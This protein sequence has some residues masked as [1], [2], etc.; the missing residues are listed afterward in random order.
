[1]KTKQKKLKFSNGEISERL[2]ER[3]DL[4]SLD[5]SASYIRNMIST[6]YGTIRKRDGLSHVAQLNLGDSP[7]I[8]SVT[9]SF[10]GGDTANLYI[11]DEI[12][13]SDVSG[14]GGLSP[15][16]DILK[17]EMPTLKVYQY[18]K[19]N[20]IIFREIIGAINA[21]TATAGVITNLSVV[22]FS[23]VPSGT[24]SFKSPTGGDP[25]IVTW[26]A[27]NTGFV[28]SATIDDG[29][30]GFS[31]TSTN[32]LYAK[33][34]VG[35]EQDGG[36]LKQTSDVKVYISEDDIT[37]TLLDTISVNTKI[38]YEVD[39]SIDY[40][41]TPATTLKYIKFEL[42]NSVQSTLIIN[43]LSIT[44][45]VGDLT[46]GYKLIPFEV[47]N[48]N[49]YLLV[50]SNEEIAIYKDDILLTFIPAPG[51][52]K[53]T[54]ENLKYTQYEDSIVFTHK[55]MVT[56]S[57]Q[58]TSFGWEY[59]D[60]PFINIPFFRFFPSRE[61]FPVDITP[62]ATEGRVKITADSS[63]FL[64][65]H[66]GQVIDGNG[67]RVRITE[68]ES[69]LV[70]FGYT[71]IPFYNT[72][73]IQAG[74]T[75]ADWGMETGYEEVWSLDKGYPITCAFYQQRLWFGGTKTKPSTLWASRINDYA[76]FKNYANYDNDSIELA[77]SSSKTN[78]I[79]NIYPNRG[80]QVF[81]TGDEF[82]VPEGTLTPTR[83][84]IVK[85]TSNGSYSSVPVVDING[86]SLF[87]EKNGKN[88]LGFVFDERQG[89]YITSQISLLSE[90]VNRPIAMTVDYN[91]VRGEGN[92]LYMVNQDGTIA[93]ACILLDQKINSFTR[94][95]TE[96]TFLDVVSLESDV[97]F[98][99]E[100]ASIVSLEKVNPV[101]SDFTTIKSPALTLTGLDIYNTLTI[102]VYNDT[103]E[104]E[105]LVVN[106]EVTLT[107]LPTEDVYVGLKFE[108]NITSNKLSV[109]MATES[110][111][112]R[113]SR[114][115][116]KT[117]DTEEIIFNGRKTIAKD[118]L[119]IFGSG[120][121]Y[122]RDNRFT[123][124]GDIKNL[125][126]ASIV[127]DMNYGG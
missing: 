75:G 81:T 53:E 101:Q 118:G 89:S 86:V 74:I 15:N 126:I 117:L 70:V 11:N 73:K 45:S 56:K 64:E 124:K 25:L 38:S 93:V 59:K 39:L 84:S 88:L 47:S 35:W 99:V 41:L 127:L 85:N 97:Y 58:R 3:S 28:N 111:K 48:E 96:G 76:D 106:G 26:V 108:Y 100:R 65:E 54:F 10:I 32:F 125:E 50:L 115:V 116:I 37:Y 95:E 120:N 104:E 51:L 91:S 78:E 110:I 36:P 98:I 119:F 33:D 21:G 6:P 103:F 83:I 79:V 114:A 61:S 107:E 82:L 17:M 67:G 42:V 60:F 102:T 68:Y 16:T 31:N 27:N 23:G 55:D 52:V 34:V 13:T 19:I 9:T 24:Y 62:S 123:I 71:M 8:P 92:Y 112:K 30:T 113:I 5:S 122:R 7:V 63:I 2:Q 46:N 87:V 18:I 94:M 49:N 72:D 40:L 1:M 44:E 22:N 20:N 90:L 80:L 77:P 43:N 57:F 29:G 12:F 121:G 69:P 105:H 109:G 66:L 14:L 4:Q